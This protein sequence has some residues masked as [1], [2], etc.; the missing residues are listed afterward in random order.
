MEKILNRLYSYTKFGIKLGLE[1]MEDLIK[2]FEYK[3]NKTKVIHIA[4]TNGKGSVASILEAVLL[5]KGYKVG[6]YTSPH[7]VEFNER[8][9]INKKKISNEKI[10]EYFEKVEKVMTEKDIKA[11]FF[12]ITTMMMLLFMSEEKV[13]YIILET[14]MGGRFDAT[15]AVQSD[16]SIITNISKDHSQY[17]GETIKEI[18]FEKAGIVKKN[19]PVFLGSN[20]IELLDEVK[21]KTKEYNSVLNIDYKITLNKKFETLIEIEKET[22]TLPLYGKFQGENFILAKKVL[23]YI[24]IKN[25]E[26]KEGIKDV[27]WPGRFEIVSSSPLT[28][29][30]GAHNEDSSEKLKETIEE[31]FSKDEV[32]LICSMLKDKDIDRV[33]NNF[34]KFTNTV[35][36]TSL[37]NSIRGMSEKEISEKGGKYFINIYEE[38]SVINAYEK[39]VS[40]NKKIIVVAGSLYLVGEFKKEV[41]V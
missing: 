37:E 2:A 29:L 6:K 8:I 25:E 17:L 7:L 16:I 34:S 32:V 35:I 26:I 36:F 18:A 28:V 19:I 31:I 22:Y 39:A 10:I 9:V 27:V 41:F 23:N 4:G 15:N 14:G 5:Y 20:Q 3:N 11:T 30:D 12:E 13:D 21:K 40:L 24:G 1:N 33:I 38:K